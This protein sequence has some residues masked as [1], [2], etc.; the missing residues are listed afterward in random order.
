MSTPCFSS[1][2]QSRS[3]GRGYFDKSSFG[4]NWAGFTKIETATASH[5]AFAACTSDEW[6]SCKAPMVGT[7]PSCL[8]PERASRQ[9]ERASGMVAHI[10]TLESQVQFHVKSLL[11]AHPD[12]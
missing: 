2:R 10:F 8:P 11:P 5:C 1:S 12:D 6:P 3:K 7:R 4:P 9:A